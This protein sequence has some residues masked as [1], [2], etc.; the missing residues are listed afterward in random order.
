MQTELVQT[1]QMLWK[2]PLPNG[3]LFPHLMGKMF[4]MQYP[5]PLLAG[6]VYLLAYLQ[7]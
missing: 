1:E 3:V 2:V 4:K 6:S 7:Q 5:F